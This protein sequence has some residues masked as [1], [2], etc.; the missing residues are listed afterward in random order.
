MMVVVLILA[1]LAGFALPAMNAMIRTQKVRSAAYDLFADLTFARSQAISLGRDITI[2]STSGTN[3]VN[4]WSMTDPGGTVLRK[5]GPFSTG[6]IF[7]GSV[8][9]LTFDRTGRASAISQFAITPTDADA[10]SA[11]MRSIKVAPSGRPNSATG[12]CA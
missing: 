3:W 10:T 12:P 5:V 4:G 6:L 11:Q 1:I 2:T 9:T 8:A 7:T